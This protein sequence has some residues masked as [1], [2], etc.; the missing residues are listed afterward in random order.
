MNFNSLDC[1]WCLLLTLFHLHLSILSCF[2]PKVHSEM[3]DSTEKTNT[4]PDHRLQTTEPDNT[5]PGPWPSACIA[6]NTWHLNRESGRQISWKFTQTRPPGQR[7]IQNRSRLGREDNCRWH[8]LLFL[9]TKTWIDTPHR[10]LTITKF[11]SVI[12]S[13]RKPCTRVGYWQERVRINQ[14][15]IVECLG[16][17]CAF[18]CLLPI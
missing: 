14:I 4:R 3:S 10:R 15:S 11:A 1:F 6:N 2:H 7:W 8:S 12:R 9:C 17:A 13:G 16:I 18:D 5:D